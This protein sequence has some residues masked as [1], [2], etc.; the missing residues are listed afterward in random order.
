[1]TISVETAS[2]QLHRA[3]DPGRLSPVVLSGLVGVAWDFDDFRCCDGAQGVRKRGFALA[4]AAGQH[5][6]ATASS[7]NFLHGLCNKHGESLSGSTGVPE[8]LMG[9]FFDRC[10]FGGPV[11]SPMRARRWSANTDGHRSPSPGA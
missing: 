6:G 1:M 9:F 5:Q 11:I 8:A 10:D 7:R 3:S 4:R 2:S